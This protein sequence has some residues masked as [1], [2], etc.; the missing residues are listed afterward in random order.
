[1]G[2][3]VWVGQILTV[4]CNVLP[5]EDV[6]VFKEDVQ[7]LVYTVQA[8]LP[9]IRLKENKD[10]INFPE[11]LTEIKHLVAFSADSESY[12]Q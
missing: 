6:A 1:M 4:L 3:L 8:L 5:N 10:R 7:Q 9:H 2:Y 11:C 12:D